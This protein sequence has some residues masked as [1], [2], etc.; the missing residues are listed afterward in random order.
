MA[1]LVKNP[2]V[3][4]E[5][6]VWSLDWKDPLEKGK[7]THSGILARSMGSQRVGHDW[8]TFTF[9][10][11]ICV[12]F[13]WFSSEMTHV[14]NLCLPYL[15]MEGISFSHSS[16][17]F[18]ENDF[19]FWH[20]HCRRWVNFFISAGSLNLAVPPSYFFF[21]PQLSRPPSKLFLCLLPSSGA[22]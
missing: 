3:V 1:Q 17:S 10:L 15:V 20:T 9:S 11:L 19:I 13:W 6:R 21:A 12:V 14:F 18:R 5:T 7:A 2:P 4:R 16:R 8:A 22:G